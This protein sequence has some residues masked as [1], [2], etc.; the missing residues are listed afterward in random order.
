MEIEEQDALQL[1][2]VRNPTTVARRVHL[3]VILGHL[4]MVEVSGNCNNKN[5]LL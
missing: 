5:I 2:A 4:A 1:I 3:K